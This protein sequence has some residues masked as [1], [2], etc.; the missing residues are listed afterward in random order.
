MTGLIE[1]LKQLET[2]EEFLDYFNIV[3]EQRVVDVYRLI[4]LQGAKG[5]TDEASLASGSEQAL[6]ERFRRRLQDAYAECRDGTSGT[7]AKAPPPAASPCETGAADAG[8]I[9][10]PLEAVMGLRRPRQD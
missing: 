10:I 6:V 2:A 4:I 7:R 8:T 3:Y 1:D 5:L 9:F